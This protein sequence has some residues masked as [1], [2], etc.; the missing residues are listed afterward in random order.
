MI[1]VSLLVFLVFRELD[2][3]SQRTQMNIIVDTN[4]MMDPKDE[5]VFHVEKLSL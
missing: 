4:E 1:E 3:L 2:I 5:I